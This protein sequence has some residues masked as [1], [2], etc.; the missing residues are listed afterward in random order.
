MKCPMCGNEIPV[1]SNLVGPYIIFQPGIKNTNE[2]GEIEVCGR[3]F[4][5][6]HL[7]TTVTEL[8]EDMKKWLT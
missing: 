8:K 1:E 2:M 6:T 3:C 7:L 4:L 5:L